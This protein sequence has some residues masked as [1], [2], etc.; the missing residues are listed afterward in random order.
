MPLLETRGA[1]SAKG[2][3]LT[4]STTAANYIEDVFSTTLYAGT[5]SYRAVDVGVADLATKG[6]LFWAKG[7]NTATFTE[8][9]KLY[10]TARAGAGGGGTLTCN[11]SL[12]TNDSALN[13]S[14]IG[15][16]HV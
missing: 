8:N 5:N 16:A 12:S 13:N 3:G 14:E 6:A 15:R 10:D 1:A 2:F 7:R 11:P 9:H 4:A